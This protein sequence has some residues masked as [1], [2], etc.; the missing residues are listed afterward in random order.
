MGIPWACRAGEYISDL[1]NNIR[2]R[3]KYLALAPEL[4]TNHRLPEH[5]AILHKIGRPGK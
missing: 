1:R 5:K 3:I 4:F 2:D